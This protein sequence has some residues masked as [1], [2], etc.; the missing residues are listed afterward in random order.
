MNLYRRK[1]PTTYRACPWLSLLKRP[2]GC[3]AN[4]GPRV[5]SCAP[6]EATSPVVEMRSA[7]AQACTRA[8]KIATGASLREHV[9]QAALQLVLNFRNELSVFHAG[10]VTA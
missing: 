1:F 4:K 10:C 7:C 6:A 5:G 9:S 2:V 8:Q 3:R